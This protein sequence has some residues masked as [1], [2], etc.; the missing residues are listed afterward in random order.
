MKK[1]YKI[2]LIACI[3]VFMFACAD[4]PITEGEEISGGDEV[5]G[6]TPQPIATGDF[7][8][9]R[10][11]DT[12][13]GNSDYLAISYGAWRTTTRESGANVP[14]VAQQKE[15]M[16]ILAAMGI[17]V[18]RTYNTQGFLGLDGISNTENL[19][20]AIDEL[21]A[22][23]SNFEMY[24]MLGIWIDAL[25]SFTD[26]EV[27]HDQESA[28]NALE[29]AAG[30]KLA[31][32]Y[33]EIVKVMAVGNEAMVHWAPYHVAPKI[34]LDHVK[35][36]QALKAAGTLNKNIWI[37]T[38]DNHASWGSLGSGSDY[39]ND[40]LKE[41]IATVDYISLHTYPFHDSFYDEGFW[42]VP[43]D[44]AE[45]TVQQQVD[46]AM[47]R[48]TNF[49][50]AQAADVQKYM[51]DLGVEKQIHIGETGWASVAN[52]NYGDAGS[53][54]AD[55]YK[56]KAFYDAMRTW[57][58]EFGASLFFFQ[59]FDEPWKGDANNAGDSE[60][61]FGLIDID[62]NVK[63]VAWDLV[64]TL[65]NAG[66]TRG[67]VSAFTQSFDGDIDS[68]METVSAPKA[69]PV[70]NEPQEGEFVILGTTLYSGASAFGWE[71]TAWA[72]INTDTSVLTVA[73]DPA[74][75]KDWGWG[76]AIGTEGQTEDLSNYTQMTFEIRGVTSA[77]SVFA[78]FQF[79]VGYQDTMGGEFGTNNFVRFNTA[80]YELTEDWVKYTIDIA[81]FNNTS[82]AGLKVVNSP[83]AIFDLQGSTITKSSIEV[84]NI[85]W[86][87]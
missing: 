84:K 49:A 24:V 44:E 45:L 25:N 76:S 53:K 29:M 40:D 18:I 66:L 3:S 78:T 22:E 9:A 46:A 39:D 57:T 33:P 15:D 80:G 5:A 70:N 48:A 43:E 77:E 63:Y 12:L 62:G 69:A 72:G 32:D 20:I 52:V 59:A 79:S 86:L 8:M 74:A 17:K 65:N 19:L 50:L 31:Q 30:I 68:L 81:D 71:D 6:F 55:E 36:L 37:T 16:K 56:Q 41:L 47:V 73:T 1:N 67:D 54:A 64:D 38:S 2:F 61:H 14:T 35:T 28:G 4:E 23:D 10:N 27:V 26:E 85:S 51:L 87:E 60:K 21:M 13:L 11:G 58:N 83:F 75:A 42:L 34:I 82:A 7:P